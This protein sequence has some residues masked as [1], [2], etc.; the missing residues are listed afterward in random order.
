MNIDIKTVM[1][2]ALNAYQLLDLHMT[3]HD[4]RAIDPFPRNHEELT[5][6]L[7]KRYPDK[8]EESDHGY[9]G[10]LL[11]SAFEFIDSC[12]KTHGIGLLA[13]LDPSFPEQLFDLKDCPAFLYYKGSPDAIEQCNT[14]AVLGAS[15]PSEFGK[16]VSRRI[17]LRV[18]ESGGVL[19]S[20]LVAGCESEAIQGC[21][22]AGGKTIAILAHGLDS[23]YL[24]ERTT[25]VEEIIERG[26]CLLSEVERLVDPQQAIATK[27]DRIL[28]ALSQAVIIVES[29]VE[30]AT[31]D[32]ARWAMDLGRKIGC[33]GYLPEVHAT[34]GAIMAGN[35]KL[36]NEGK[37]TRLVD[38][39]DL[40]AFLVN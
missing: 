25:L 28:A 16:K 12:R 21:H 39:K 23:P 1:V 13:C 35:D 33:M 38:K 26:G 40:E 32:T 3:A 18:A 36:V 27:H 6:F 17:G 19:V 9:V 34:E 22:E 31:M 30:S 7:A 8:Y 37:A 29:D 15:N 11:W 10:F 4:I 14:V 24:E 20:R 5:D 2:V